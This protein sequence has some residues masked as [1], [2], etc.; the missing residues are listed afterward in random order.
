MRVHTV[1]GSGLLRGVMIGAVISMVQ[2]IRRASR[3]HVAVLGRIPGTRR[4]SDLERHPDNE[5]VPRMLIFRTESSL[6]YFNIDHVRDTI[7]DR[8]R[9]ESPPPELVL[10][11][12]SST[13]FV[14][15]QSAQ[16]LAGLSDEL[17]ASG[18]TLQA[19][20]ARASVRDRLRKE[21]IDAKLGGINRWASVADAVDAFPSGESREPTPSPYPPS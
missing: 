2:L 18:I 13:P 12:L 8:V 19:V 20:E 7:L 15:L 21:G 14:D 3:P 6:V 16:T 4:F 5:P 1:L 9:A 10:L 11:D 17:A